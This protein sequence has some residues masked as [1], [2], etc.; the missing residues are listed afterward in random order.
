MPNNKFITLLSSLFIMTGGSSAYAQT[1]PQNIQQDTVTE[2]KAKQPEVP[3]QTISIAVKNN[4]LSVDLVNANL[5]EII[6]SIA[7]KAGFSIEGNSSAFSKTITTKFN[8]LDMDRGI[9]RIFS[10]VKENNY[11]INYDSKGAISKLE[12][13]GSG[14]VDSVPQP[15]T[16]PQVSPVRP[17]VRPPSAAPSPRPAIQRTSP[18]VTRSVPQVPPQPSAPEEMPEDPGIEFEDLPEEDIKEVPYVLP[19]RKPVYIPPIKR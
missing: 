12:I 10:L 7:Q 6:Q 8:D 17:Q 5:G 11:L 2:K 1:P 4:R 15:T 3:R 19:Q 16:R 14:A 13:Y 18:P 9:M